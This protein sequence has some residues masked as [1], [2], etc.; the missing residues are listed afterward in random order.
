MN[1]TRVLF[2]DQPTEEVSRPLFDAK[3]LAGLDQ[4]LAS[5][6]ADVVELFDFSEEPQEQP[7]RVSRWMQALFG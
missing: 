3:D 6:H 2:E 1:Q 5:D 7:S 4:D